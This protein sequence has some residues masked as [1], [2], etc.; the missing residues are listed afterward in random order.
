MK[1]SSRLRKTA[2]LSE[3]VHHQLNMYAL[4]AT[5]AGVGMLAF[6]QPSEAEIVYTPSHLAIKRWLV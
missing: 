5:A 2:K 1:R 6:V 3:S 4:A